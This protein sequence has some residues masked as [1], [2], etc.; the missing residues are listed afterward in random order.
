MHFQQTTTI[1]KFADTSADRATILSRFDKA[2][3]LKMN[4]VDRRLKKLIPTDV[5]H[6]VNGVWTAKRT[7]LHN[8]IIA[9]IF[10]SKVVKAATPKPGEKPVFTILGGRGGSGKSWFEGKVF[11]PKKSVTLDADAIKKQ[12]PEY[13][14]FNAF[15]VHEESSYIFD[16]ATAIAQEAGLNLTHDA[17]MKTTK[18]AISLVKD[19]KKAGYDVDAHYMF[20]PPQEAAVRAVARF[21]GPTG[22]YVPPEVVLSNTTN[23]ASFDAIK[24]LTRSWSFMDN[25]VPRGHP[26]LLIARKE[27]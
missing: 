22:R 11:N 19:M 1:K 17:T 24:H 2:T 12:L 6:Q 21:N 5:K 7:E 8:K 3:E 16:K 10:N 14:G 18:K 26:P 13:K 4:A 15:Q 20:L 27:L 23:E 9:D 25:S